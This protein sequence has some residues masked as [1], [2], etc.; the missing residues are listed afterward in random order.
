MTSTSRAAVVSFSL[1]FLGACASAG[2]GA[3]APAIV[4]QA[5]ERIPP[6][7]AFPPGDQRIAYNDALSNEQ[8]GWRAEQDRKADQA[9]QPLEAAARGFLAFLQRFPNTGWD[10]TFRFHAAD[11]LRR[12]GRAD[13]AT[14]LAEQVANDP[15]ASPKTK[16]M[17]WLQV[18]NAQTAA[19]KIEPLEVEAPA[20]LG[21][22][23]AASEPPPPGGATSM[24]ATP[25]SGRSLPAPRSRPTASSAPD[26]SRSSPRG[27]PMRPATWTT[28]ARG[29]PRSSTGGRTIRRR[30]RA[31][32]RCTSRPSS[33]P[34]TGTAP[35]TRSIE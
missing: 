11:L 17:A 30:S 6:I 9:K 27:S 22:R 7:A 4:H 15:R 3:Q 19:G 10:L 25:I 13:E 16:A 23:A 8:V 33:P 5:D 1:M 29:S 32:R 14:S 2:R 34:A 21:E 35:P 12:T 20:D 26:S 28:P 18:A 24:P 31:P